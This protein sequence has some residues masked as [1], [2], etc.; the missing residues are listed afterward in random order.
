M[1]GIKEIAIADFQ[2]TD[3]S[4]SQIATQLQSMVMETEYYDI[5]EREKLRQVLEEQN[6][7]M[8]GV[9]DEATAARIGAML[10]VDALIFGDV[11]MYDVEDMEMEKTVKERRGT[12]K[13]RTVEKKDK[14]T[15]EVKQVKEEIY[16]EVF[17]PYK[18]WVRK[19]NVAIN[20]RIVDVE[21]G[22]LLA[23]HSESNSYDSEKDRSFMQKIT[24]SRQM[25]PKAEILDNLSRSICRKFAKMIAPYRTRE[26]RTIEP[27]PGNIGVGV[28]YAESGLWPEAKEAWEK[29][30]VELP[31]ESA[32]MYNLGLA[33][34]IEGL[35]D[36]AEDAYK[37]ALEKKSKTRYM[38]AI[39]RIRKRKE[40]QKKLQQ[41]M[42]ER[43]EKER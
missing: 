2:G 35:L 27:G 40:E 17:V 28:K 1:P 4:G 15:G 33:Y 3:R 39:A 18:Y 7:G 23:A 12:G 41:Q 14:K 42:E 5:M 10:G 11:T 26:D 36:E 21:S 19:G 43:D 31:E 6:L 16:E 32:P 37:L 22:R 30:I 38:E 8:S 9:V 34:E 24:D 29:A 25:K 13:Y 20:F